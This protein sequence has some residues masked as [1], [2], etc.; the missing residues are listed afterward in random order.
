MTTT[1]SAQTNTK[2]LVALDDEGSA[3][4]DFYIDDGESITPTQ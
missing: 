2:L 1:A 4:G 3:S